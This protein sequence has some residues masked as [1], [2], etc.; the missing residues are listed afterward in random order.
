MLATPARRET[1]DFSDP[2]FPY[3]EGLVVQAAD[4]KDYRTLDDLKGETVGVQVGTV[5]VDFLKK[6]GGFAEIKI[7]D[8]LADILR[9]LSLGRIKAGIGDRPILA[10]QLSQNKDFKVK[11]ARN[12]QPG[13]SGSIGIGVRKGDKDLLQ[14][15]NKGLAKIKGDGTLDKILEKWNLK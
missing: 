14:R 15:V 12:Y 8:S 4:E 6:H 3:P 7:Y 13:M 1:I 10:Y 11:L 2:V 5:Y 9:D